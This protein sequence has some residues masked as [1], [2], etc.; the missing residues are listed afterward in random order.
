MRGS[1][2]AKDANFNMQY[3]LHKCAE[4][5]TPKMICAPYGGLVFINDSQQ[6]WWW[7]GIGTTKFDGNKCPSCHKKLEEIFL[8]TEYKDLDFNIEI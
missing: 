3:K 5:I 1:N 4:W 6:S 2:P 8:E 7:A